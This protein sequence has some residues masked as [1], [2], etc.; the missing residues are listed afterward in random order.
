[1]QKG[2]PDLVKKIIQKTCF[3][4]CSETELE[5]AGRETSTGFA[6]DMNAKTSCS[7]MVSYPDSR[8][9]CMSTI[10]SLPAPLSELASV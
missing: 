6:R 2:S 7:G 8:W 5:L 1:M 4:W 3:A 10:A 9:A